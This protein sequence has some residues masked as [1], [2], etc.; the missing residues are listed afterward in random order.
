MAE[1]GATL[2]VSAAAEPTVE[3]SYHVSGASWR[4]LYDLR[5]DGERLWCPT[6]PR[7]PSNRV[8]TGR[9]PS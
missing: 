6:W 5:V 9:S 4:P 1:V 7:S 3:V 2:E 8:R